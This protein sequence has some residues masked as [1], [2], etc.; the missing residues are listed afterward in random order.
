MLRKHKSSIFIFLILER[1]RRE[2]LKRFEPIL[3]VHEKLSKIIEE[4]MDAKGK[5][6]FFYDY[7]SFELFQLLCSRGLVE[8]M[9]FA[10]QF[11]AT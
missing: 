8:A 11:E 9:L 5:F 10:S 1:I 2:I 7:K 4:L 3:N 6:L